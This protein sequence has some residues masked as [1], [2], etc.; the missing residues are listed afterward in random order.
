VGIDKDGPRSVALYG[1]MS[2]DLCSLCLAFPQERIFRLSGKGSNERTNGEDDRRVSGVSKYGERNASVRARANTE[3]RSRSQV[4]SKASSSRS[5][6]MPSEDGRNRKHSCNR[7][8][9]PMQ[10]GLPCMLNPFVLLN[11]T[12]NQ[13]AD[14]KAKIQATKNL[15]KACMT[16][17]QDS[18][19]ER[20]SAVQSLSPFCALALQFTIEF[21]LRFAQFAGQA[22]SASFSSIPHS[23]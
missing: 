3:A 5:S 11:T 8:D 15:L 1:E 18:N 17:C 20:V 10:L 12:D 16:V 22:L 9:G 21:T 2:H 6:T 19:A 13:K 4:R 14:I 23:D 7:N